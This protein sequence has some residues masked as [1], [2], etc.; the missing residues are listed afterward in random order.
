MGR[1]ILQNDVAIA[2]RIDNN[3]AKRQCATNDATTTTVIS[4]NGRTTR[5]L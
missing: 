3:Y 1:I 4:R 2:R 5:Q